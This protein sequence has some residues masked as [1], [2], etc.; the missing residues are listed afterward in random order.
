M[1]FYIC[2]ILTLACRH[3]VVPTLEKICRGNALFAAAPILTETCLSFL[4]DVAADT[5]LD[6]ARMDANG[7]CATAARPAAPPESC[8]IGTCVI[9]G[10]RR[11]Q[12]AEADALRPLV[13]RG[14]SGRWWEAEAAAQETGC[15]GVWCP[16]RC[17]RLVAS[18]RRL[19]CGNQ[20]TQKNHRST[21]GTTRSRMFVII[22]SDTEARTPR[23]AAQ[24]AAAARRKRLL[25]RASAQLRESARKAR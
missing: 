19:G 20:Q 1:F 21:R 15:S 7:R 2:K 17:H 4:R 18:D 11:S 24:E 23:T 5:V 22:R 3:F 16:A 9:G 6:A 8:H 14:G 10:G 25:Q 12:G 13:R